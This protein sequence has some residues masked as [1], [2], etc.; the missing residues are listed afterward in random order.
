MAGTFS[1]A[2]IARALSTQSASTS[3]KR[4]YQRVTGFV[5]PA[6]K[7]PLINLVLNRNNNLGLTFR[8]NSSK[9]ST[10]K[11]RLRTRSV[12]SRRRSASRKRRRGRSWPTSS[13]SVRRSAGRRRSKR[14]RSECRRSARR[15]RRGARR[16]LQCRLRLKLRHARRPSWPRLRGPGRLQPP[17]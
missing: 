10:S 6:S 11:E 3:I 4:T 7:F 17:R 5:K 16:R 1:A 9:S 13:G 15:R 14:R 8:R 12:P 2:I